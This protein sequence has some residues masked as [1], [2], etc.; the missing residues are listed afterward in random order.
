MSADDAPMAGQ[1]PVYAPLAGVR[2]LDMATVVAAPL[3]ATLC[4]DLGADTVKLELPAGTDTLRTLAPVLNGKPVWWKVANRGKRGITLDVRKPAGR[5]LLLRMLPRF[6]VLVENFRTG[7]LAGWGLDTATLLG[8]NPRLVVLRLTGFGQTGP[9]AR[10]PGFARV[11]EAMT[12]YTSLTK[13]ADGT[14]LH[15]DFPLGDA[16][17]GLYAAFCIAAEMV[18]LRDDPQARGREVDLAASE[19][20]LRLLDPI[21]AEHVLCGTV[22]QPRGSSAS[23]TAPSNIYC[24]ADG[25]HFS[26]AASSDE[27]FR[28]LAQGLGRKDWLADPRFGHNASRRTHTALIDAE[29]AQSFA[30]M[31]FDDIVELLDRIA[32][33]FS[34]VN[35]IRDVLAD[36]HF[37]A[38]QAFVHCADPDFGVLPTACVVPRSPGYQSL[39]P[40]SGP[41]VGQHND[42]FYGELGLQPDEFEQLRSDGVI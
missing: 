1:L 8:A 20:L 35:D 4:A 37:S 29:V 3:G 40:T 24:S 16:V 10:R 31:Q 15:A 25:V 13:S 26:M 17:A 32:V 18:R 34:K 36:P 11:F 14:P 42:A 38:R 30:A 23:Y 2:I 5:D 41:S 39:T 12:G 22:R 21:A 6:D 19:A 9:Y 7:T 28:R 27:M 33:P